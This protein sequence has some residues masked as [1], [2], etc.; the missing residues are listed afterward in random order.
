[1]NH[2][3]INLLSPIII[4]GVYHND[5]LKSFLTES[6]DLYTLFYKIGTNK[7]YNTRSISKEELEEIIKLLKSPIEKVSIDQLQQF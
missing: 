4:R 2:R 3:S 1:M 7:W 5:K 6:C